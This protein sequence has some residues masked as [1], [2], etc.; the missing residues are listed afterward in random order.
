VLAFPGHTPGNVYYDCSYVH[1]FSGS[2][3]LCGK[4]LLVRNGIRSVCLR[5]DF[6]PFDILFGALLSVPI[7]VSN[8]PPLLKETDSISLTAKHLGL[9]LV[10]S[11]SQSRDLDLTNEDLLAGTADPGHPFFAPVLLMQRPDLRRKQDPSQ[12]RHNQPAGEGQPGPLGPTHSHYATASLVCGGSRSARDG[13][14]KGRCGTKNGSFPR[15]GKMPIPMILALPKSPP[16]PTAW[17]SFLSEESTNQTGPP[18][19]PAGEPLK[20]DKR[21]TILFG[22]ERGEQWQSQQ[23]P[24]IRRSK[25]SPPT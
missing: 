18:F 5:L 12:H 7:G 22:T 25:I 2:C 23:W 13:T 20:L 3:L 19:A 14:L 21:R 9:D 15:P 16:K 1:R 8:Q 4:V 17:L 10:L 11:M 24:A 6:D